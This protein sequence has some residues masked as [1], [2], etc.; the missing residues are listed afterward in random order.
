MGGAAADIKYVTRLFF[1]II[2]GILG[3]WLA[4]QFVPEVEFEGPIQTLAFCGF[5][6]GL[7]N[8]FL[9]P[10]LNMITF[11]LRI[12]TF[13]LFSLVI[14]MLMIWIVDILFIELDIPNLSR[15]FWTT[16]IIWGLSFFFG[17]Y[18]PRIRRRE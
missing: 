12:L 9:K 7:L 13:G 18:T 4:V 8:F 5:I 3:L 10:I 1:Q 17:F 11:P 15:L 16:L 2:T 6:L 14:N